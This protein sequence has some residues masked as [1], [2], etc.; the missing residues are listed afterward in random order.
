MITPTYTLLRRHVRALVRDVPKARKLL[1]TMDGTG[2]LELAPANITQPA[3]LLPEFFRGVRQ[4]VHCAAVTVGPK[5]GD[6]EDRSKYMQGVK[7]Y[8]PTIVGATPEMV[9]GSP[10]GERAKCSRPKNRHF[11]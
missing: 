3:T 6:T 7:F 8:D 5:E 11:T 1:G 4:V 9:R 2:I 10:T